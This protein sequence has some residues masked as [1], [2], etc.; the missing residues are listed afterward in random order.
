MSIVS[1][2]EGLKQRPEHIRQRA[3]FWWAFGITAVI[4]VFWIASLSISLRS[5]SPA[6]AVAART[7]SPGASLVAGVGAIAGD[8][9][10]LIV[11]PK[12]VAYSPGLEISPAQSPQQ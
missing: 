9:W 7:A 3:A 5:S 12:K 2:I 4:A 1:Y 11:G 10:S 6:S 8:I